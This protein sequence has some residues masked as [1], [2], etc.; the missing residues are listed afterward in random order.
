MLSMEEAWPSSF[1]F[2]S[3]N[4]SSAEALMKRGGQLE[5]SPFSVTI[6]A[7]DLRTERIIV[8]SIQVIDESRSPSVG[9]DEAQA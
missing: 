9:K 5:G 6:S 1:T 7:H 3:R 8:S 2:V 4:C